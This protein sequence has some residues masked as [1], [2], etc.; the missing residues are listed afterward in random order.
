MPLPTD[1]KATWPPPDIAPYTR[2][3]RAW[4]AWW[5]GDPDKLTQT[6]TGGGTTGRRTFWG[7]RNQGSD[8]TKATRHLHATLA[9]DIA[10]TSADLLFGEFPTLTIPNDAA[11]AD[12]ALAQARLEELS[13]TIGLPNRLL[14]GAEACAATGGVYL[15]PMWDTDVADHPLLT[16][17]GA[18][19]AVPDFRFGVLTAVTFHEVVHED[20][21]EIWRHLERHEPGVILHGLY[22]GDTSHLGRRVPLTA[23]PAT[24]GLEEAVTDHVAVVG[25]RLL[26]QYVPNVLPNRKHPRLPIGRSD[27]AGSEG[28]LDALDETWTSWMRDLRLGQARMFVPDEFMTPMGAGPFGTTRAAPQPGAPSGFD[29]DTE[30]LA[31]LNIADLSQ[32]SGEVI[33]PV[34][35]K[36]R[37]EE[38]QTT[39]LT[40]TDAIVSAAG[41]APTTFGLGIDGQAESGTARRI[42]EAK[43][44]RTQARK[45][46]YWEPAIAGVCETLLAL[47]AAV[48]GRK[49]PVGRPDVG[50]QDMTAD[51]IGTAAWIETMARAQAISIE[52]RVRLGQ[53]DLDG[54]QVAEEV[55]RIKTEQGVGLPDPAPGLELP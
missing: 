38:H 4:S 27:Y 32:V 55:A 8:A 46:R 17:V 25:R 54:V 33:K 49:V 22:V 24:A 10:S 44:W 43:T 45:Q 23:H 37:V 19:Q 5:S 31:G 47:D 35:F 53:P 9:A 39:C 29:V 7:R 26:V 2:D 21:T 6:T 48:F 14:E 41:Y 20:R 1:D 3:A 30:L 12:A 50:W 36:I 42:R 15:R 51:P 40:L 52:T 18:D 16:V 34:Q 28:F 13:D 11:Q